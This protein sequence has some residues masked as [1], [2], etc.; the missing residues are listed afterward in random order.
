MKNILF[1]L[2]A[3]FFLNSCS[4]TYFIVRHAEKEIPATTASMATSGDPQLSAEGKVR[5][6]ELRET[7]KDKKIQSI[8]STNTI[9]TI[10]TAKP[11]SD[12]R[13]IQIELYNHRDTLAL[14]IHRL[15]NTKKGNVLIIGHSN[16]VDDVV[17]KLC[18]ETIIPKDLLERQ[19][20]NLYVVKKKGKKYLFENKKYG[21]TTN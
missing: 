6:I 4:T 2:V 8:F 11:L 18:G 3:M 13:G 9:R 17:N 19:Y 7:L 14:F 21:T 20:D 10:S 5:A 16:T 1:L 12:L 15:N